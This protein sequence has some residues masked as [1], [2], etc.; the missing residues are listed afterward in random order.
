MATVVETAVTPASGELRVLIRGVGWQ[1][2]QTLLSMVADQPVR[3]TYDRGDVELMSPLYKH[4]RN[5]SLLA[6]MVEILT[7]ELGIPLIAAGATTLKREDLDR[8]LE[9][10]ASFYVG[11]LTRIKDRHNLDL[12][13]DPPPDLAIEIEITR[14]ALNRLGLYGVLGVPEIWRFDGRTLR[15]LD[16][17][18]DGSY[19]EIFRSQAL[20]WISI[21][22]IGRFAQF[23]ETHDDTQWARTLRAWV[24]EAVLPCLGQVAEDGPGAGSAI[25]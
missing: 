4:E 11:D 9:A 10:D 8:G 23:E 20:P 22:E 24:R 3:L 15:I 1:G 25:S 17:Q 16:R 12:E 13:I 21:E 14:S 5:R 2:Y 7:E 18:T 19:R 6:R